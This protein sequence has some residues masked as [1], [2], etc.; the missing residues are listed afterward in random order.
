MTTRFKTSGANQILNGILSVD[1]ASELT[2]TLAPG[3]AMIVWAKQK[4][5]SLL[6]LIVV[7]AKFPDGNIIKIHK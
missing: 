4:A 6:A 5:A 7:I 2:S 3:G 1:F